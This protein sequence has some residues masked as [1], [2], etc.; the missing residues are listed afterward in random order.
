[1]LSSPFFQYVEKQK[2]KGIFK[3][4]AQ[5]RLDFIDEFKINYLICTNEV[6]LDSTL[7]KKIKQEIKDEKTGERFI[8]LK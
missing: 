4:I 1:M 3:N 5:S 7:V 8:L 2:Q 6:K